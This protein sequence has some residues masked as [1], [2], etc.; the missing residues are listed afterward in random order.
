MATKKGEDS[1]WNP[2]C[3]SVPQGV[4]ALLTELAYCPGVAVLAEVAP[5]A[6]GTLR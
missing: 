6:F 1:L 4:R 5:V 3:L 2:P